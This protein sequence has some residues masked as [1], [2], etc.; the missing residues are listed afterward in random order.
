M[1]PLLERP[2][3]RS[4]LIA[5]GAAGRVREMRV[6][7]GL[8]AE[9]SDALRAIAGRPLPDRTRCRMQ[10][11]ARRAGEGARK[12]VRPCAVPGRRSA[13]RPPTLKSKAATAACG[14]LIVGPPNY[15]GAA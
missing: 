9:L 10:C 2:A 15:S 8:S 5:D 14:R 4:S 3:S 11:A 13:L 12:T 6:R 7:A 1:A